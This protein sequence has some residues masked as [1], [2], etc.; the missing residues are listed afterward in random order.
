MPD[1]EPRKSR[2]QVVAEL[3]EQRSRSTDRPRPRSTVLAEVGKTVAELRTAA[4][5]LDRL[6]IEAR[7][8]GATWQEIGQA[9]RVTAQ[10]AHRRYSPEALQAEV[11]R[12]SRVR[13]GQTASPPAKS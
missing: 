10:T 3:I 4:Q 13:A 12:Q 7:H 1:D 11:E 2:P 5:K 9:L 8:V 6:V